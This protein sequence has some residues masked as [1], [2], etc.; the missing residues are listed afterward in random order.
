MLT[1]PLNIFRA[2]TGLEVDWKGWG[3]LRAINLLEEYP[4]LIQV[5]RQPPPGRVVPATSAAR[6]DLEA[7]LGE[8][9][10][11]YT[12]VPRYN[13]PNQNNELQVGNCRLA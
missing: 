13:G 5:I 10:P 9:V 2:A 6:I 8:V 3:F 4:E 1:S 7:F 12:G 11:T